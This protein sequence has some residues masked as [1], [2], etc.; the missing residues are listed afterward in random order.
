MARQIAHGHCHAGGLRVR[1]E[2][3]CVP[4]RSPA[5]AIRS[6]G[7]D[8]EALIAPVII[9]LHSIRNASPFWSFLPQVAKS[10]RGQRQRLAGLELS[11]TSQCIRSTDFSAFGHRRRAP[12]DRHCIH[13]RPRKAAQ[14]CP[15]RRREHGAQLRPNAVPGELTGHLGERLGRIVSVLGDA[16]H[17]PAAWRRN[18]IAALMARAASGLSFQQTMTVPADIDAGARPAISTGRPQPTSNCSTKSAGRPFALFARPTTT[19]S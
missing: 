8:F 12:R 10:R 14:G 3:L 2:T 4:R 1:R 11:S 6:A 18:G 5:Q 9:P 17:D 16:H 15:P 19:R 7:Q 13:G